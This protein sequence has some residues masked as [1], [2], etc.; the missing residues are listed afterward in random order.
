MLPAM[1][2]C[3]DGV[4]D[5]V[6][7][8]GAVTLRLTVVLWTNDP[9]VPVMVNVLVPTGVEAE[10]VTVRVAEPAGLTD[11]G[12]SVAVA[13]AGRPLTVKSTGLLNPLTLPRLTV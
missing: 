10:V 9:L 6:K 12:V 13:P 1:T 2:V 11:A 7:F 5:K 3:E 4:A 8:G